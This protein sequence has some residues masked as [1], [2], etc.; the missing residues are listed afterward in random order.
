MGQFSV[1]ILTSTGSVLG[2]IQQTNYLH[3]GTAKMGA[4]GDQMAVLG[5]KLLGNELPEAGLAMMY[6]LQMTH[7]RAVIWKGAVVVGGS[8]T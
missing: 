2:D 4:G 3:A 8:V 5:P 7:K 6:L 1:T